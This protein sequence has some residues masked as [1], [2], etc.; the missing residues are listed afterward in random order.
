MPRVSACPELIHLSGLR[1]WVGMGPGMVGLG[2][3][4]HGH[5]P[6]KRQSDSSMGYGM[7]GCGH[8]MGSAGKAGIACSRTAGTMA[9][10]T[11][12]VHAGRSVPAAGAERQKNEAGD[13]LG[14]AESRS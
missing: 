8:I 14:P 10:D 2:S 11:F 5:G 7:R 12:P 1:L 9:T 3:G 4:Y 6:G 13:A